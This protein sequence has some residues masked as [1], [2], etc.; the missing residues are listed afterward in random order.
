MGAIARK[1]V[2]SMGRPRKRPEYK[3]PTYRER[4]VLRLFDLAEASGLSND[5]I[6]R[7]VKVKPITVSKWL[8]GKNV[9][10]MKYWPRLAKVFRI[11][12]RELPPES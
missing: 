3:S 7:A 12:V 1:M 8:Q 2:G 9:P 11:T 5:A 6:A 10:D 4:F